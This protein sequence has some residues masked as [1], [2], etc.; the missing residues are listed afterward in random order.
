MHPADP[1]SVASPDRPKSRSVRPLGRFAGYLSRYPVSVTLTLV[2]LLVSAGAELAIGEGF[3]LVVN[4]GLSANNLGSINRSFLIFSAVA[5]LFAASSQLRY[6][7]VTELAE[8]AV[9]D[10]RRDL[11]GH[12]VRL[13]TA[14]LSQTTPAEVHARLTSDTIVVQQVLSA[15]VAIALR[16]VCVFLGAGA[17]MLWTSPRLASLV[18]CYLPILLL[19][20]W[21]MGGML[22]RFSRRAQDQ[23]AS[24]GGSADEALRAIH[25]V[26][27]FNR[28]AFESD[29][30]S[31]A[32]DRARKS[33]VQCAAIRAVFAGLLITGIF[34]LIIGVLWM[35][36]RDLMAGRMTG[37][38]LTAFVV[39]ALLMAGA[40][41]GITEMW[42]D[43]QR[44]AGASQRIFELMDTPPTIVA[45]AQ[46]VPLPVPPRGQ[47]EFDAVTFTYPQ[48]TEPAVVRFSLQVQP[49]ETVALVGPSG[50]G[51]STIFHLLERFYDP[52]EGQIKLDGV[53]LRDAEPGAVRSRLALVA[54]DSMVF[55]NSPLENIRYGRFD[56][57]DEDV[58]KAAEDAA[59][60]GFIEAL[61]D[62]YHT[63]LGENG[64]RLSGGQR[65]RLAIAR[66]MVRGAA[67]LLLDEAT[68]SLDS[69]N[70]RLVQEAIERLATGQTTLIIA[71]RLSTVLKADRIVVLD[72][73]QIV[74][75]GK[76]HELLDKCDLYARLAYLQFGLKTP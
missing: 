17:M 31:Q 66:S 1:R 11:F 13:D 49:G 16:N 26:Q 42:S 57:S 24:V 46:P 69:E 4:D 45:P 12:V 39:Y 37:G 71:H 6:L 20:V 62:G 30:F 36:A 48:R 68:A 61:P 27:A 67:V 54:Q 47:I 63:P 51:K 76:H 29:R 74:A 64:S 65:Q 3:R 34:L 15:T 44:A 73:G 53:D 7:M 14:Q 50:A 55:N 8:R 25:T 32:S 23:L 56:A 52:Q 10:L 60:H 70:E 22:R 40:M 58:R 33:A 35:G 5:V 19:P 41:R 18:V 28:E 21:T 43:L 9:M 72:A 2:V 75:V 38:D 59:A